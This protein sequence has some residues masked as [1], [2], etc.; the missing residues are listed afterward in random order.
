[1]KRLHLLLG[2]LGV[3][4]LAALV[5]A[6]TLLPVFAEES[7]PS[8]PSQSL[9]LPAPHRIVIT[10]VQTGLATAGDEFVELYN[11]GTTAIDITGWQV[12]Y[13]NATAAASSLVATIGGEG[14]QPV[15]EPGAYYVLHTATVVVP[16]GTQGQV[17]T[18][19]LSAADKTV[20][21]FAPDPAT[22]QAQVRD[23]VA[24]GDAVHGAGVSVASTVTGD[25][26]LYRY[27][28]PTGDFADSNNN[29]S[30]FGVQVSGATDSAV[31]LP[32]PGAVN[33]VPLPA[34]LQSLSGQ[35]AKLADVRMAG[36]ALPEE[37]DPEEPVLPPAA[38]AP[39]APPTSPP[40]IV[41]PATPDDK[42]APEPSIPT[43]NNG[44]Y[45]PQISEVLPNPAKPQ[46]DA[47]DEF[48]ELYNSNAV[49]FELSGFIVE[50]G[51]KTKKRYVFPQGTLLA[52][53]SFTA[54]Y[55]KD[56]NLT[57]SNTQ[58]QV[59]L[60][61]PLRRTIAA[62]ES[63]AA[64][65][66]GQSWLTADNKWQWSTRPTPSA[67][68]VLQ[69]PAGQKGASTTTRANA[70]APAVK[71]ASSGG[72]VPQDGNAVAPAEDAAKEQAG[73]NP[74]HPAILAITGVVAVSYGIYEYRTD[75]ANKFHQFRA[76]RAARAEARRASAGR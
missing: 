60:L 48:V 56:T 17:V 53:K 58:G 13:Q 72:A 63:Y 49:P 75:L 64:A 76:N 52:A 57:L 33:T 73:F 15:L 51:A 34:G 68:N 1:M 65:K 8:N 3:T 59:W 31:V 19:K 42:A 40:A 55:A 43:R 54:F 67:I 9:G 20:G 69:P 66:D 29:A 22:C 6:A 12:R 74:L 26:L 11:A 44:L 21:L 28:D 39:V 61:D 5:M 14:Q 45:A 27:V 18:A 23:A 16:A 2:L 70:P 37:E 30:D 32:T 36:C 10:E 4:G 71:G 35:P 62:S 47:D 7:T 46:T 24:W 50:A 41:Q 38:P 25:K